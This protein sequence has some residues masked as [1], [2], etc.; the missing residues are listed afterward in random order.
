MNFFLIKSHLAHLFA[1]FW[2]GICIIAFNG[3]GK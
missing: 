3:S 2:Q 1:G